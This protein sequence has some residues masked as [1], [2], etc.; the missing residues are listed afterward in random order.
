[1]FKSTVFFFYL[2]VRAGSTVWQRVDGFL[3]AYIAFVYFSIDYFISVNSHLLAPTC[4]IYHC[5]S[6]Y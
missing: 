1:M 5:N 4:H 2:T 3:V 6:T